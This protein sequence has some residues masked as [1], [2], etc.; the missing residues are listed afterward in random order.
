M[1][2]VRLSP[3]AN[4]VPSALVFT[5]GASVDP[6]DY[7]VKIAVADGARVGSLDLPVHASLLDLGRVRLTELL[8]GGPLPPVNLLRPSVDARVSFGSVHGYLE[9]YGPDSRDARR[10]V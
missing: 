10:A 1:T 7:T 3:A 2:D 8:A 4:G 6:G 9:A 5:G